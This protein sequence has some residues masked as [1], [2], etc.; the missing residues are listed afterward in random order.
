MPLPILETPTYELILPSTGKKVTYRPFLVKEY[1]ILLTALETETNEITRILLE[2][3]DNCTFN[4]LDVN[5][6]SHFDVEYIFINLRAKS[7]GENTDLVYK[8]SCDFTNE[9]NINLLDV[10]IKNIENFTNKLMITEDVGVIM[11]YPKFDEMMDIYGSM[12]TEKVITLIGSCIEK[13]FTK[14]E[15]FETIDTPKEEIDAFLESFNKDQFALL[16]NY[17]V[18]MPKVVHELTHN[19]TSCGKE[20]NIVLEGLQNFFV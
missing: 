12:N 14:E 1:K 6:L 15:V 5:K 3:I 4:K 13:I 17:F 20:N 18:N 8:C 11:R 16:E 10:Q 7:I 2:L 19:C 9:F